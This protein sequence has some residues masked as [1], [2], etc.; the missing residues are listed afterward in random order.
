MRARKYDR[1]IGVYK[2]TLSADGYGG[3]TVTESYIGESWCKIATVSN[4]SRYAGRLAD[5]GITEPLEALIV[6]MRYRND[7]AL[8]IISY[9]LVYNGYK[10][11]IQSLT[12][13]DLKNVDMELICVQKGTTTT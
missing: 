8:D 4:N 5:L 1:R 9:Y 3:N 6:T 7:I 2:T 11:V 12:N 10:Y 13:I